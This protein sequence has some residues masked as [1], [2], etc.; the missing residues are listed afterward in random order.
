MNYV[1]INSMRILILGNNYCAESFFNN[2]K[3]RENDIVFTNCSKVKSSVKYTDERDLIDFCEANEI[4]FVL[5]T[6]KT[7][8]VES[9]LEKLNSLNITVFAPTSEAIKIC[10]YKSYV[11]KFINK[12]KFLSPKYFIAEKLNMATDYLKST[13]LP[14][15]IHP[16]ETT[17]SECVQFAETYRDAQKIINKFFESGNKKIVLED[18]IQGKNFTIW[19]ISDGYSAKIMGIN[20]KYQNKIGMSDPHFVTNELKQN[21]LENVINPAIA[22]LAEEEEYIGILGFNF[23][24]DNKNN[25]Y[26]LGFNCFF[27]E[28]SVDFYTNCC[29][30]DWIDVF[31][32]CII[33]NIFSK[34][35][36]KANDEY[37]LT[38]K[39]D[40]E[41]KFISSKIK[42]NLDKYVSEL[43]YDTQ[44]Y[45][46]AIQLWK[47]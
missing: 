23:I 39:T 30:I 3:N 31:E 16:E 43:G 41:I 32:S 19:T 10:K 4:N 8:M 24:L 12:N 44:D 25:P 36:F 26:L 2:L 46:E 7:Y 13:N 5:I 1:I 20:A 21:L 35:D 18:Y 47:Y 34:Y 15:A 17:E 27:D 29:E 6:D 45:K 28:I 11:K 38:I 22:S 14:V 37:A 40:N 33:G 9:F 42:S